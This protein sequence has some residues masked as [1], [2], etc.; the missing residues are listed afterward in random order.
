LKDLVE[1]SP[2]RAAARDAR[3][4]RIPLFKV[5][6]PP[7]Q[8]LLPRLEE[9]LYSGQIG[10]GEIVKQ[11]EA[12]FGRFI[13]NPRALAVSSGTAALHT[14]LLLA[15][16][17]PG[18]EVISTPMTAEPTNM[19]ILHTGA[20]IVWADVDPESGNMAPASLLGKLSPRTKAVV[21]VHYA[22]VPVRLREIAEIAAR[23]GVPVVEDAAHALGAWYGGAKI[24]N[25]SEYVIFSFQAIKHM[26]TGDGGM[27]LCRSDE[28][29]PRGRRIRWFGI[30]R[31]Q[32]RTSVDVR[33][34]GFKYNTNNVTATFGLAQLE[35]IE[36]VIQRHM[37]NGAF[38]ERVLA[39]VP[40]VSVCSYEPVA[41]PSH[42]LY[43][44]LAERRDD[45]ARWLTERGVDCSQVHR[46]NDLHPVFQASRCPLPGLDE[47][48]GRMLHIPCGW[49]V[50]DE[51]REYIAD[52]IRTGW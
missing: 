41:R 40:G 43:T 13:G 9:V 2:S 8:S 33:D 51:E 24:G 23:H 28:D 52:C 45:L 38:F 47:Y 15:N 29:L 18:D 37:E 42:W 19:A 36:Q 35:V 4:G 1:A 14:A 16:V 32:P 39:D 49:W 48:Y 34:V 27:L 3:P 44:V 6:V 21:V 5:H 22:G 31:A 12:E 26:T 50:G 30:D 17:G 25:H 7:R 11:F 46:R 20:T 10:D